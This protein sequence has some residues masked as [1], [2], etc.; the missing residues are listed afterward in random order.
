M[1]SSSRRAIARIAV[2]AA[3]FLSAVAIPAIGQ[4]N[5]PNK[6]VRFVVP[7]PPGGTNDTLARLLG[8]KLSTLWG[9]PVVVDNRAG[10][11]GAIGTEVAA[12]SAGD[13]YTMLMTSDTHVITP[14]LTKTPY[15]PIADFAPVA[16][17]ATTEIMLVVNPGVPANTLQEF[18]ALLKSR[19]GQ[20]NFASPGQGNSLHLIGEQ[21]LAMTG[22]KMVHVPYKGAGPA[23]AELIGGQVQAFFSPPINVVQHAKA[24]KL[25]AL[26]VSGPR[27]LETMPDVPTFA[28]AGLQNFD[29]RVWQG[30]FVPA[31]TPKEIVSKIATDLEKV[32][33]DETVRTDL[34]KGGMDSAFIGP[35]QFAGMLRSD[36]A[37]YQKIISQANVKLD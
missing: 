13:G 7:F 6:P 20:L 22:T 16:V 15:D 35:S 27:R 17:V 28:E 3:V 37:K 34:T 10:A 26:A 30:V 19:P 11:N 4:S 1:T 23:V 9:Q 12:K 24:G 32:M 5:Y 21:F 29:V 33:T 14:L 18:I 2:V 25:K 8:Q 31:S 36:A